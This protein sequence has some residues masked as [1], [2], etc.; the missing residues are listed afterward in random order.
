MTGA[1][2]AYAVLGALDV[3][4]DGRSI[5]LPSGRQRRALAVLLVH[6]GRPVAADL[7][8]EAIWDG[9]TVADPSAALYTVMS[10]LRTS[11]GPERLVTEPAGYRLVATPAMIDA[12][13]FELLRDSALDR[14]PYE[15]AALLDEALGLWRGAAYLEFADDDF[16]R[17]EATR[18]DQLR[19]DSL[20]DRAA[21]ALQ[22]GQ[23]GEAVTAMED[24]IAHEPFRERAYSLLMRALYESGR[25]VAALETF[26]RYRTLLADELGL[27]PSP[28]LCTLHAHIL[29]HDDQGRSPGDVVRSR[30]PTGP[31]SEAPA[32][33][34]IAL[35][36]FVGREVDAARLLD[37]VTAHRL[38]CVTG[39]GGVGKTRLVA[40]SL[41][42]IGRRLD[43]PVV[44]VELA[45]TRAGLVDTAVARAL[46]L[47]PAQWPV[48]DA[49]LEYLSVAAL[50]LIM[51]NCE[52]VLDET[53]T[54]LHA[55]GRRCPGVHV[56][57]TSRRRLD[58][59]GEHVLPLEPL[60]VPEPDVPAHAARLSAAV[61]L[62]TDRLRAVRP[63]FDLT[64]DALPMVVD[65]CRRLDGLPLALEL[66]ASRAAT[67]GLPALHDHLG[68]A[69]DILGEGPTL[70]RVVEWSYRLLD[71]GEQTLLAELSVFD[72]PFDLDAAEQVAGVATPGVAVRLAGLAEASLLV[73][74][75]SGGPARYRLLRIVRAFAAEQLA[76]HRRCDELE[77]ARARWA[78]RLAGECA[79]A[80]TGPSSGA[81]FARL[82]RGLANLTSAVRWCLHHRRL[83]QAELIV[84]PL[85]LCP[86]GLATA[87]LYRLT[88]RVAE[89]PGV[90]A[91]PDAA[92]A[93]GAGAEAAMQTG[94]LDRA[95]RLAELARRHATTPAE[96][97]LAL[98]CLGIVAL[99]TGERDRAIRWWDD[100]LAVHDLPTAYRA[101]AY[102]CLALLHCYFGEPGAA[103]ARAEAAR[104]SADEADAAAFRAFATYVG[105]EVL[106]TDH[107]GAAVTVLRDAAT[108]ADRAGRGCAGHVGVVARIALL[109]A[110]VR[111]GRH[112]EAVD[113]A[114]QVLHRQ[115]RA[116]T[117]PQLWTTVRILAEL[118]AA[119]GRYSPA[120]LLL[121]AADA[122]TF[123]PLL[124]GADVARH[125]RL[126]E[127]LRR[128][129]AAEERAG[130]TTLARGLSRAEVVARA[131]DTLAALR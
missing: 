15:A 67:L 54:L 68:A 98:L 125:Q 73:L 33:W 55:V 30:R 22:L 82:D 19:W 47:G 128:H 10:R 104:R 84:G 83:E 65:V 106:L 124:A 40:E 70:R 127:R 107:P 53:R 80:V 1:G 94:E 71:A 100:L 20:E 60:P 52:H 92:L 7:L 26:R 45:G 96:H 42:A 44:V 32:D 61:R 63:S 29:G 102:S 79:A 93:L 57:A 37:A 38:V 129:L 31:V 9:A 48:R 23:S 56:L 89:H 8:I 12:A 117:W 39:P 88:I 66:A 118:F 97:Y 49:L 91:T 2:T 116:G 112:R 11:L 25:Q 110:L 34:P 123:A 130:I 43:A 16:A 6:A 74:V 119:L 13:R 24:L 17:A 120:Q 105:G 115:L 18:L 21:L 51:D 64:M 101:D 4:R 46:R 95:A 58:C 50:V 111:L 90:L 99:Y 62:F 131:Q 14:P 41:R 85:G 122:A 36:A 87:E 113:L 86:H 126:Q 3:C 103:R 114:R 121:A 77:V 81:A 75:D 5:R 27:D 76:A 108:Q 28:A 35:N 59:A 69:L 109:S 72:G 78:G